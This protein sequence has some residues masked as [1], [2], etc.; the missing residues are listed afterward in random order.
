MCAENE[1]CIYILIVPVNNVQYEIFEL[2]T[3][4]SKIEQRADESAFLYPIQLSLRLCESVRRHQQHIG[5]DWHLLRPAEK[6]GALLVRVEPLCPLRHA[7]AHREHAE[8]RLQRHL[9]VLRELRQ[10]R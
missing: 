6:P 5:G 9:R 3:K 4:T 2:H 1:K 8:S 10:A 7:S